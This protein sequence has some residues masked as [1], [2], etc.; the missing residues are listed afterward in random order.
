MFGK[1]IIILSFIVAVTSGYCLHLDKMEFHCV[2]LC[3]VA[4]VFVNKYPHITAAVTED[5]SSQTGNII[6]YTL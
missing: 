3:L 2:L 5:C 1:K 4:Y 6:L